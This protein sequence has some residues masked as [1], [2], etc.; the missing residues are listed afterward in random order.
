MRA[1]L[2]TNVIISALFW[3]GPPRRA[4]DLAVAGRFQVVTSA[5]LLAEI[6]CVLAE[7]FRVPSKRLDDILADVLS[8][9]EVVSPAQAVPVRVRDQADVKVIACAI[10]GRAD[11]IVTGDRDLLA[12]GEVGSIRIVTVRAF[13]QEV[14]E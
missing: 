4:V 13:L 11:F 2:D 9:A 3:S 5:P 14:G 12:L 1:V 10:G 6:E 7:D 8:Y